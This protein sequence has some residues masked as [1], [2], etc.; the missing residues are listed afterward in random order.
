MPDRLPRGRC[1]T[2][3]L[4]DQIG[5]DREVRCKN[6]PPPPTPPRHSQGRMGGGKMKRPGLSVSNVGRCD[7]RAAAT[8]EAPRRSRGR[9][10]RGAAALEAYRLPSPRSRSE[11]RGGGGGGGNAARSNAAIL[12]LQ[13]RHREVPVQLRLTTDL[14]TG[15]L[16]VSLGLF[17]IVYG[18]N[19]PI[20]TPSRIGPGYYPLLVSSG[21]VL[22]GLIL[23]GRS[24]V[25]PGD[26]IEGIALRPLVFVLLGTV[27]F[28]LLVEKAGFVISGI[29][30]VVLARLA[31][32]DFRPLEVALL[33]AGLVAF[34]A[35][36]FWLGLSL[37]LHPFPRW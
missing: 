31:D 12:P 2:K 7:L 19:Y 23:V 21:L 15:L 13:S 33:A 37:P 5:T 24:L 6:G 35:L 34:I 30:V 26:R 11:W 17:A 36:L 28:G 14:V 29:L 25:I 10:I 3:R 27:L 4:A 20:G 18:W 22:L 16:F 32:R 8:C 1:A 9:G